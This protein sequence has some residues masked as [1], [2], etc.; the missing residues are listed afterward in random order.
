MFITVDLAKYLRL[1]DVVVLKKASL[2]SKRHI[3]VF[4]QQEWNTTTRLIHLTND[5][6]PVLFNFELV[7]P[8]SLPHCSHALRNVSLWTQSHPLQLTTLHPCLN[9]L[10]IILYSEHSVNSWPPPHLFTRPWAKTMQLTLQVKYLHVLMHRPIPS[11]KLNTNHPIS[12]KCPTIS[13]I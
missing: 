3:H 2:Y 8:P 9:Y 12:R 4:L 10:P 13:Y 1:R 7:N 6:I 5:S 11:C